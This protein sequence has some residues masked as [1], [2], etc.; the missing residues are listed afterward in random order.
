MASIH[1]NLSEQK[2]AFTYKEFNSHRIGEEHQRD[3]RFVVV[4]TIMA[5]VTSYENAL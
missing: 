3:R 4:N 1:A 5:A 2:K